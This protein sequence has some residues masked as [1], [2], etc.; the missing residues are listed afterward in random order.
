M[1]TLRP[2]TSEDADETYLAWFRDAEIRRFIAQVPRDLGAAKA[3]V[4]SRLN[5]PRCRYYA[6]EADGRRV[7]TLKLERGQVG[8]V[9]LG[10]LIGVAAARGQGIGTT[11]IDLG[12]QEAIHQMQA[13]VVTAGIDPDN[14]P[15]LHAFR[16]AKFGLRFYMDHGHARVVAWRAG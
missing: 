15:S 10:L 2:M 11:A 5:D 13:V 8:G 16:K 3:Y 9:V 14:T 12:Y 1:T 4:D 7:G 6:I